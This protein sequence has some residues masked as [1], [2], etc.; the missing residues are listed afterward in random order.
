[1]KKRSKQSKVSIK[2][3]LCLSILIFGISIFSSMSVSSTTVFYDPP[4]YSSLTPHDP[5]SITID[6]GFDVFPGSG[7]VEDPYIIEGYNI[8]TP[9]D[10]GIYI[11][12]TTK[13]FVIRNCYVDAGNNGIYISF[14]TGGTATIINNTCNNNYYNGIRIFSSST[15]TN[16]ICSKNGHGIY[17]SSSGGSTVANNTCNNNDQGITLSTSASSTVVNNTCNYN[18]DYGIYLSSS[19]ITVAN[20]TCSNNVNYG[21]R[22][23][24]TE[25]STVT[26]NTCSNNDNYGIYLQSSAFCVVTYNLLQENIGYGIRLYSI[27]DNTLIHHNN[28]I[29]NNLGGTSQALDDGT[30]NIWYDLTY[31]EGNYWSDWSGT[32]SYAVDGSSSAFDLYPLDELAVYIVRPVIANI[33]HSPSTPTELDSITI[34]ATITDASGIHNV[35]LH[36]RVNGGTW[37]EVS[38]TLVSGNLYS[39]TIGPFAVSDTI[40]YYIS[41][42]DN[43]V[44]HNEAIENNNGEYYDI[45]VGSSDVTG[46]SITSIF[47]SPSS[48]TELETITINATVTDASGIHNVTL[49]Y[50]INGGTWIEVSMTHVSGD[51]YSVTIGPFAVSDTIEYYI[52]AIDNSIIHYETTADNGGL[53]YSLSVGSSDVTG[54]TIDEIVQSPSSPTELDTVSINTTIT[55]ASGVQSVTLHYRVNSG[56]WIEVS[57]TLIS[58]DLYSVTIGSF[59]VSD[60]IEYYIITVDNS[61]NH[62]EATADNGG[63]YYVLTIGSSDTSG[64]SIIG[65][66]QSPSSPTELDTVTVNATVTD[67]SGLLSV[68]LHYRVNGGTWQTISMTLLS[69]D[70]YSVVFGPFAVSDTIE[71][72]ISAV[73]NSVNHNEA[74]DDSSGLFYSFTVSEVI[75]EFQTLFPLLPTLTFLFLVCGLAMQQRRKK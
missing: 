22:L 16:N 39:V 75:P 49:H 71:Y 38:M 23:S 41:A 26:N 31:L 66:V 65:V 25:S 33:I 45:F 59:A 44:N 58:G 70:L 1:M 3:I 46:P 52:T 73:D 17:L 69:G 54:P 37:I 61:I 4:S 5:I 47:H 57:M 13:Y 68:T 60:T 42:L 14:I 6:S 50:R 15:V 10:N 2:S 43:S 53:Y 7:T 8:T 67:T 51:I 12:G 18:N 27:S 28:F 30:D 62:N 63:L 56:T 9:D 24:E 64:P 19:D 32:G 21:I 20:N 48:P 34:N 11:S 55:D 40:E 35:T 36:Y 29:D 74:I 72:Y